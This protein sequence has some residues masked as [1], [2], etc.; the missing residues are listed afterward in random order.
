[1]SDPV[2]AAAG[3][4]VTKE[5]IAKQLSKPSL[6]KVRVM[7]HLPCVSH[8]AILQCSMQSAPA[9][10]AELV[11]HQRWRLPTR[12]L[13]QV[14]SLHGGGEKPRLAAGRR[15]LAMSSLTMTTHQC[16]PSAAIRA[17]SRPRRRTGFDSKGTRLLN[18]RL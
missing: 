13:G 14:I 10:S 2:C 5:A 3:K 6:V 17:L 7:V 11:I 9:G 4:I 16:L 18:S 15:M 12:I 1:M 8:G